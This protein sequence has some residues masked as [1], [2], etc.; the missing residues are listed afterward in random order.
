MMHWGADASACVC[1]YTFVVHSSIMIHGYE[2]AISPRHERKINSYI[3]AVF[4]VVA[5]VI[6]I[7]LVVAATKVVVDVIYSKKSIVFFNCS[8]TRHIR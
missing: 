8:Y 4:V 7:L 1:P 5:I 3:I 2:L 6:V